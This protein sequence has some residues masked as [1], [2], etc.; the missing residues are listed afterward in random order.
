[1]KQLLIKDWELIKGSKNFYFA[2]FFLAGGVTGNYGDSQFFAMIPVIFSYYFFVNLNAY[3]YKYNASKFIL[4]MPVNRREWV[5]SKYMLCIITCIFSFIVL[6]AMRIPFWTIGVLADSFPKDMYILVTIHSI[7][8]IYLGIAQ[9]GY[10]KF[11]YMKMRL[12][13]IVSMI[14]MGALNNLSIL[15]VERYGINIMGMV[16][17][18]LVSLGVYYLSFLTSVKITE[19]KIVL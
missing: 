8:L 17:F 16:L 13:N 4:S 14:V 12:V 3:D 1:M 11:G 9:M 15:F 7:T 18:L 5:A 19:E 10:F 6:L 2:L